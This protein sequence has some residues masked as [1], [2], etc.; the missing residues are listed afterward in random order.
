MI[1]TQPNYETTPPRDT[2]MS[3]WG[4]PREGADVFAINAGE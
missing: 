3:I 2:G 4:P 1:T